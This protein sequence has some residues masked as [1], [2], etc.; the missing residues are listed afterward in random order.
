MGG[1]KD[2][3]KVSGKRGKNYIFFYHLPLPLFQ[4]HELEETLRRLGQQAGVIGTIV[5]NS[6]GG[7]LESEISV[8]FSDQELQ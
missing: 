1:N 7:Y 6:E 5:V 8:T 2:K 4:A 3:N